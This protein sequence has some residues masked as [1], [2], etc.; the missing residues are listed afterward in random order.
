[1]LLSEAMAGLQCVHRLVRV[2]T[3]SQRQ[4]RHRDTLTKGRWKI[5]AFS[6]G[7]V[8]CN[9]KEKED[10]ESFPLSAKLT[11]RQTLHRSRRH[12]SPLERISSLLPPEDLSPEVMQLR[13]QI[14]QEAGE[15]AG[16]QAS[17]TGCT[18]DNRGGDEKPKNCD[19]D[20]PLTSDSAVESV[21]SATLPGESLLAFGEQLVAEYRK[22][23]RVEYRKMFQLQPGARLQSSWGIILHDNIAGQPAGRFL[24]TGKGVPILIRRASLE[25][26][27]LFMKRGPAIAYP[28]VHSLFV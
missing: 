12:L 3:Y 26:Y 5:R 11:N 1:M 4:I 10:P 15:D 27:V 25:D 6:T 9:E 20:H 21:T 22:K 2:I 13:E 28:K 19:S 23:G 17:A 24:Q 14:Q 18:Q 7:S 8:K 16:N